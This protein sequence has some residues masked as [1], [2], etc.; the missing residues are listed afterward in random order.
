VLKDERGF[1]STAKEVRTF[2]DMQDAIIE[3]GKLNNDTTTRNRIKRLINQ[4]NQEISGDKMYRWSG[5]T[6][7]LVIKAAYST[8]TIT[9]TQGSQEVTG[10]STA[11]TSSFEGYKIRLTGNVR[12]YT[13]LRVASTT[14]LTLDAPWTETTAS[15]QTYQMFKDEYGLFPDLLNIRRIT[16]PNVRTSLQPISP[17]KMD[18][19]RSCLYGYGAYPRV[20]TINGAGYYKAKTWQTFL[21]S[22]DFFEDNP[23]VI[24]PRNKNMII[25]PVQN[26]TDIVARIRYSLVVPTLIADNDEPLMDRHQRS[27]LVY[28]V[29]TKH[30][31]RD[32]DAASLGLWRAFCKERLQKLSSTVETTDDELI[33]SVRKKDPME[34]PTDPDRL[35]R[36]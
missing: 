32:R 5:K 1:M 27:L 30:F 12:V 23:D 6:L 4:S 11:W 36:Y 35:M 31:A 16:I 9:L 25:W 33:M 21:L 28:D 13:V 2:L 19:V 34:R 20:Y 18:D 24:P 8:G 3:E 10:V 7:P 17:H 15:T 26:V 14:A 22:Q 29:L